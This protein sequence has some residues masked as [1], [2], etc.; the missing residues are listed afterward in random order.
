VW[1][2]LALQRLWHDSLGFVPLDLTTLLREH[3]TILDSGASKAIWAS[4]TRRRHA[5]TTQN[6]ELYGRVRPA[7]PT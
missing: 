1:T 2:T 7:H 4:R 6:G 5:V 3:D